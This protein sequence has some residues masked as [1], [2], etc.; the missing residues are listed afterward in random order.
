M[1]KYCITIVLA[2]LSSVAGPEVFSQIY[3]TFK[4]VE[5]RMN[6]IGT[7]RI[8]CTYDYSWLKDTLSVMDEKGNFVSGDSA[9]VVR[10]TMLL[11]CGGTLS[12]WY[13]YDRYYADSLILA[14]MNGKKT[15]VSPSSVKLGSA[16]TVYKNYPQGKLTMTDM[17]ATENYVVEENTPD[18]GWKMTGEWKERD[19]YRLRKATCD[20][21]GRSYVAWFAPEVPVSDGP[22]KFSGLPGLIFE[23][24]DTGNRFSF[25]L[26]GLEMKE[27]TV[28]MPDLNYVKT[29]LRKY[30]QTMYRFIESPMSFNID[31]SSIYSVTVRKQDEDDMGSTAPKYSFIEIL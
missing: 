2:V 1:K 14:S 29:N 19:G 13:S 20:F 5:C 24:H 21:R 7:Y 8:E 18:F 9:A 28:L 23:V 27:G 26:K 15:T 10:E 12:K 30:Y 3:I 22:W 25:V 6:D 31:A 4:P 17:I 16:L 11:Q